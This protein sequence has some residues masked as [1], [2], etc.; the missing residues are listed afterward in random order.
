MAASN[1]AWAQSANNVMKKPETSL[2]S[3]NFEEA[4]KRIEKNYAGWSDKVNPKTQKKFDKITA[5]TKAKVVKISDPAECYFAMSEWFEF[6]EDGHMFINIPHPYVKPEEPGALEKR[7]AKQPMADFASEDAFRK[8]L[9]K[10]K[11]LTDIEGI[12]ETDDK[13]Y[14][15]GIASAGKGRFEAFLLAD[16]DNLWKAGKVKFKLKQ[17][18]GTEFDNEYFYADFTSTSKT[19]RLVKD[20]LV[21][22]DVFKMRKMYPAPVEL[23]NNYDLLHKLPDYRVEKIDA[24]TALI[25]LP[26]FTL[27]DAAD[28]VLDMVNKNLDII[29]QTENLVIDLRN[30]PGGDENVFAS[31]YPYIADGPIVRKGG[32]FRATEENIVQLNHELESIQDYPKY[33][34]TL[35]PKL[36]EVITKMRNNIG[37]EIVGPNRVFQYSS[38]SPYPKKV[39][40]L[41]NENTAS[42]AESVAMEARQSGKTIIIGTKTKGT[43][44]FIEV[45]DWGLPAYGWRVAF[46]MA[47]SSVDPNYD[48]KGITPDVKVPKKEVDWIGF[49]AEYLSK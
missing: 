8:Y 44:D 2:C 31:L 19:S 28:Y 43:A 45:R 10:N 1:M 30:N 38:T 41:V 29:T 34:R 22:E 5:T 35:G 20:Y 39:A 27:Y 6:F 47:K 17:V 33:K 46:G 23:V 24:K 21:I 11:E 15:L 4:Y 16:R 25:K 36:N 42:T 12:W 26:P 40:I 7:A 3:R 32:T 49:A 18:S 13:N 9:D 48:N 14:K 37:S